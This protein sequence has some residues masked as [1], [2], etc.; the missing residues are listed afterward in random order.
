MAEMGIQL[1]EL[2]HLAICSPT[3]V[4]APRVLQ[5]NPGDS[6]KTARSIKARCKF[7]S[8]S[9]V[10]VGETVACCGLD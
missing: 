2:T 10:V 3:K 5:V 1:V 6:V 9:L 7:A 8:D 4:A